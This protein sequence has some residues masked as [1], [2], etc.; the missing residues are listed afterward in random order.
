[1]ARE[2]DP[3]GLRTMGVITKPDDL[4]VGSESEL[5]YINLARNEDICFVLEGMFNAIEIMSQGIV[6]RKLVISLRKNSSP[7][8]SGWTFLAGSLVYI[9]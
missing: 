4:P 1:M 5:A 7:R 6:Q 2:F 3:T 8:V 9:H